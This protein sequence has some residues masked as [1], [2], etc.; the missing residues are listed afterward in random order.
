M[1]IYTS[2]EWEEITYVKRFFLLNSSSVKCVDSMLFLCCHNGRNRLIIEKKTTITYFTTLFL[3]TS[4]S[5]FHSL[6]L[7]PFVNYLSAMEVSLSLSSMFLGGTDEKSLSIFLSSM[8]IHKK[9]KRRERMSVPSERS[10]F[11]SSSL[12]M[13]SLLL[14]FSF[15]F[16]YLTICKG[17]IIVD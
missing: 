5:S 10:S 1:T 13:I 17:W 15:N 12:V 7:S 8:R 14:I 3:R 11:S 6:S 4:Y 2:F 9:K 16:Y